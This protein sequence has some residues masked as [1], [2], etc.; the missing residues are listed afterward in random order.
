MQK[1]KIVPEL[2]D[3]PDLDPLQ[4]QQALVGLARLNRFTGVAD[5]MYRELRRFSLQ[6]PRPLRV[7]DIATGSGDLPIAWLCR[8]RRERLPLRLTGVDIS[9]TALS[10]ASARADSQGVDAEWLVANAIEDDLPNDFDVVTCSLFIH[11]LQDDDVLRLLRAMRDATEGGG[12]L[13]RL[14]ICDLQRSRLNWWLVKLGAHLLSRSPIVHVDSGLSVEAALTRAEF[15]NLVE[16]AI[17][18]KPKVRRLIPARFICE[19]PVD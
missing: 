16:A 6:S 2:M 8:A 5:S 10:V 9:A 19:I 12:V 1:R 14:L 11:H 4:H 13:R 7:L 18:V 17:D 3:A 15:S